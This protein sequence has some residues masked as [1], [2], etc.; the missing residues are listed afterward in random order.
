MHSHILSLDKKSWTRS[1]ESRPNLFRVERKHRPNCGLEFHFW[2]WIFCFFLPLFLPTV[3]NGATWCRLP[4][5]MSMFGFWAMA[6]QRP[7]TKARPHFFEYPPPDRHR[8]SPPLPKPLKLPL[9]EGAAWL[10]DAP[11][12]APKLHARFFRSVSF[13]RFV[14]LLFCKIE[15]RDKLRNNSQKNKNRKKD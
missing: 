6:C 13:F 1:F 12:P 5:C 3:Q 7:M 14:S 8:P 15:R 10:G 4:L 9:W 11:S 2:F